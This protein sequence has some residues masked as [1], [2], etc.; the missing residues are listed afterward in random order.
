MYM[1]AKCKDWMSSQ[2][3]TY[4]IEELQWLT[5]NLEQSGDP[6]QSH[7]TNGKYDELPLLSSYKI[8]GDGSMKG[9]VFL[10]FFFSLIKLSTAQIQGLFSQISTQPERR[11]IKLNLFQ[12][13]PLLKRRRETLNEVSWLY[14][15]PN[16]PLPA[17]TDIF[18]MQL[19]QFGG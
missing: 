15:M 7:A 17:T 14:I 9:R 2:S 13:W 18:Q 4:Q 10:F 5:Q 6:P 8:C 1:P 19:T 11:K 3:S 16:T 12:E